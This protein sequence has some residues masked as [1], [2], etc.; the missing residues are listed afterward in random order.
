[1][2]CEKCGIQTG[3]YDLFDYC[4]ICGKNLCDRC[5]EAGCCG[6]IPAVS[7]QMN[8]DMEDMRID[9]EIMSEESRSFPKGGESRG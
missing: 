3:G 6:H 1:M 7:G 9:Y 4:A 5:M 8:D 2:T